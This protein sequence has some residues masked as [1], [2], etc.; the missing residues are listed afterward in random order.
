[1][2]LKMLSLNTSSQNLQEGGRSETTG[3]LGTVTHVQYVFVKGSSQRESPL[4]PQ[5]IIQ[6]LSCEIN[7]PSSYLSF[8]DPSLSYLINLMIQ[9]LA[10]PTI[11]LSVNFPEPCP[12]RVTVATMTTPL[13]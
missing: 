7:P 13:C 8:S 5:A 4:Q 2:E 10:S 3:D 1:M 12:G 6:L 9:C 11:F